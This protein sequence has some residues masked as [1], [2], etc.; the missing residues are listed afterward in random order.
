[1][2][3]WLRA[4]AGLVEHA[5]GPSA[6]EADTESPEP[7]TLRQAGEHKEITSLNNTERDERRAY[8]TTVLAHPNGVFITPGDASCPGHTEP[9]LQ[10]HSNQKLRYFV[11]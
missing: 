3:Q 10:R 4:P 9:A 11:Q 7:S 6:E 1:M 2:D 8:F 5:N